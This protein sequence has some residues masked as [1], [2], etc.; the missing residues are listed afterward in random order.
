MK[1][2]LELS[3]E[4]AAIAQSG[5][6]YSRDPFDL[7]RFARLREMAGELLQTSGLPDFR[8]PDETGYPTPKVDVR[9]AIFQEGRVLLIR[10]ASTQL[11]TLPGGWADVNESPGENIE[12]ECREETGYEVTAVAL[13]SV[14][15]RER[16]GFPRN[17][18]SI[19]KLYFLC[20]I[21]GGN[22]APGL[23]SS[24]IEFFAMASLP[25]LDLHR[26]RQEDI[27]QAYAVH[28]NRATAVA[29]N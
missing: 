1:T 26:C 2:L 18:H 13:T 19:Y 11:W 22:P 27:E 21:T 25:E 3:R 24:E 12:R 4:L 15:D 9:G 7:G 16:A 29:F 5:L 20:E 6:T 14:I 10:E 8:W 17:A 28:Q 23:E